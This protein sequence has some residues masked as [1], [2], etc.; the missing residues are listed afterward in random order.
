MKFS[1]CVEAVFKQIDTLEAMERTAACGYKAFE[2]WG[3][4]NKELGEI[5]EK[6]NELALSI[7]GFICAS[8]SLVDANRKN[9]A[10]E[11]VKKSVKAAQEAGAS[12]L[13][14]LTGQELVNVSRGV[15]HDNI[16]NALKLCAPIVEAAGITLVLEPLNTRIDHAGYYLQTSSEGFDIIREVA[17]PNIK[18]LFDIYHQQ[19][20]E[21]NVI[22]NIVENIDLIGHF[23]AA[24]NPGRNELTRG[25]LNYDNIF[26]AIDETGYKGYIG[27]EY[28]PINAPEEG[29]KAILKA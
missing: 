19:I 20:T 27:L 22:R 21:G 8:G 24:G 2:F 6:A 5:K 17:S 29:L 26:K 13:L 14:L 16:V 1:V 7:V 12:N 3:F 18:L 15:Q 4:E 10:V 11:G 25:E 9:E 23:H 28:F